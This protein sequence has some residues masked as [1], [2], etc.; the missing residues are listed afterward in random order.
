M[1]NVTVSGGNVSDTKVALHASYNGTHVGVWT[2]T[3]ANCSGVYGTKSL[4]F[5]EMWTSPSN[6]SIKDSITFKAFVM[7][8]NMTY[9]K[10]LML[11][12]APMT[13]VPPTTIPPST[14]GANTMTSAATV[15][16]TSGAITF[17][18]LGG[19]ASILLLFIS[20]RELLL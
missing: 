4:P 10:S 17:K 9:Y 3:N 5:T 20:V 13:T 11:A 6:N 18:P 16:T 14:M 8:G 12:S 1:Y 2:N 7:F 15:K 19:F